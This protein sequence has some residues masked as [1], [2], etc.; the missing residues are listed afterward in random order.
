VGHLWGVGRI[1]LNLRQAKAGFRGEDCMSKQ[2]TKTVVKILFLVCSVMAM[3]LSPGLVAHANSTAPP[4][5]V[6]LTFDYETPQTLR[7]LGVQ[8]I[9][10]ATTGCEQPV[11]LEQYG[12]CDGAGCVASPPRMTGSQNDFGCASGTC[13]SSAYPSHGG[14]DFRL[15]AQF[16]DRVR[17]SAVVSRLPSQ[18][19]ETAAWRVIV[20]ETGLTLEQDATIPALRDPLVLFRDNLWRLGLSIVVELLVAGLCFQVWARTDAGGLMGRLW[21]VLLV[22]LLSLPVVWL[23]FPSLGQLQTEATQGMGVFVLFVALAYAALLASI[24]RSDAKTRQ[25]LTVLTLISL[26]VAGVGSFVV[27]ALTSYMGSRTVIVEGLSSNLTILVSEVFAVVFEAIL[28]SILSK[29]SLSSRWIWLTSLL[30]NAAS[31]GA[32]LMLTTVWK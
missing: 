25:W 24:Y 4:S 27:W 15:V 13:R 31:F 12:V 23:F 8:L 19:G 28:I 22:N 5:V 26:P 6:W 20:R 2:S 11:L 14:T 16:S 7:L 21:M 3:F 1:T 17:S 9:A 10:C 32:G 18:Y 29:R 30:M